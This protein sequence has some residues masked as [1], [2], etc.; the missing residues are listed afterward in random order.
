[1]AKIGRS[2]ANESFR[3]DEFS[4]AANFIFG[5]RDQF[6]GRVLGQEVIGNLFAF[7]RIKRAVGEDNNAAGPDD[8]HRMIE[9]FRL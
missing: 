1:M 2:R 6:D 5:D 3:S 8:R 9:K 4:E 7:E